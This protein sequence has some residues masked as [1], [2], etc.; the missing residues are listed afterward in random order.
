M[1]FAYRHIHNI[2]FVNGIQWYRQKSNRLLVNHFIECTKRSRN[3]NKT[4]TKRKNVWYWF[5]WFNSQPVVFCNFLLFVFFPFFFFLSSIDFHV[6]FFFVFI[7]AVDQWWLLPIRLFILNQC[8]CDTVNH[9]K[10]FTYAKPLVYA[11]A[12]C[13]FFSYIRNW[14]IQKQNWKKINIKIK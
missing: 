6:Y 14:D 7:L 5:R 13:S 10:R 1:Y 8:S 9:K 2:A 4:W 3:K 12:N 11:Q